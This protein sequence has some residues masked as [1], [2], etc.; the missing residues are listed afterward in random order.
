MVSINCQIKITF[1]TNKISDIKLK[2]NK[3][4][5]TYKMLQKFFLFFKGC[6]YNKD[7]FFEIPIAGVL[8]GMLTREF[9]TFL[10]HSRLKEY[11]WFQHLYSNK[12]VIWL[13][14]EYISLF[15]YSKI[16]WCI[17]GLFNYPKCNSVGLT[18]IHNHIGNICEKKH[19]KNISWK[20]CYLK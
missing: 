16:I 18:L 14:R 11:H 3:T 2:Y 20:F 12:Q 6:A 19:W 7:Y 13:C 10:W 17:R 1:F 5:F 4:S 9:T 8:K 15:F